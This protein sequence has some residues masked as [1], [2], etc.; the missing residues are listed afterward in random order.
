[1]RISVTRTGRGQRIVSQLRWRGNRSLQLIAS[2][3]R[4]AFV[5]SLPCRNTVPEIGPGTE[6]TETESP[7]NY[8]NELWPCGLL[9]VG[10][11]YTKG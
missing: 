4:K 8:G 9:P 11:C 2:G 6:T 3:F 5:V 10:N 1:M 7:T